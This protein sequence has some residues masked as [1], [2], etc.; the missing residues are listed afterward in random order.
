[1]GTAMAVVT[2]VAASSSSHASRRLASIQ[3]ASGRKRATSS[4]SAWGSRVSISAVRLTSSCAASVAAPL[5]S[6]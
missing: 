3:A 2:A 4:S 6:T 5:P 1:M